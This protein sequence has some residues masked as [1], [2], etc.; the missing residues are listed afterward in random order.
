MPPILGFAPVDDLSGRLLTPGQ[1]V[2]VLL[3][4]HRPAEEDPTPSQLNRTGGT[5]PRCRPQVQNS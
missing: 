4:V 2:L 1:L 5:Q 3:E